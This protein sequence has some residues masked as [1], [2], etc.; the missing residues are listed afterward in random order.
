MPH[1]GFKTRVEH[2]KS[3]VL[4]RKIIHTDDIH[5]TASRV[6]A[7][8]VP[9]QRLVN[10]STHIVLV[11]GYA[12]S[13]SGQRG[14]L[15]RIHSTKHHSSARP[16]LDRVGLLPPP[17]FEFREVIAFFRRWPIPGSYPPITLLIG[18][19]HGREKDKAVKDLLY[20]GL[21][22]L[23]GFP[24]DETAPVYSASPPLILRGLTFWFGSRSS[25]E[26]LNYALLG[27]AMAGLGDYM[28]EKKYYRTSWYN[29]IEIGREGRGV[30]WFRPLGEGCG[31]EAS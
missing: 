11:T 14:A 4:E 23:R 10:R 27:A 21:A 8:L 29:E 7:A 6:M 22:V 24:L 18:T 3:C 12:S 31:Q 26:T 20:G 15:Q 28:A 1:E 5:R 9:H 2:S 17:E 16:R 13:N 25:N 19:G 30:L